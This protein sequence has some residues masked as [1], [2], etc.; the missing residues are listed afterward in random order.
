MP[1]ASWLMAK[2]GWSR[3]VGEKP[4]NRR[5]HNR[6]PNR[7]IGHIEFNNRMARSIEHRGGR[8]G[9][10][11]IAGITVIGVGKIIA[12][13]EAVGGVVLHKSISGKLISRALDI[14]RP[15]ADSGSAGSGLIGEPAKYPGL[16]TCLNC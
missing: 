6:V 16:D 7:I 3:T 4:L 15:R 12:I 5:R 13:V 1:R 8:A 11:G 2:M 14:V 10:I 9:D